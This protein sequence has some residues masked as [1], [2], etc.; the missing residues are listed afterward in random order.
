MAFSE[1]FLEELRARAGLAD[2]ISR[3]VKLARKGR[4]HLGLCPFHKEKTPSFTVNEEKGFYHC[5]GCG[6]HGSVFDFV[7]ET[8]GLTFPEAVEK[9]AGE[10]GLEVPRATPEDR[11]R[12]KQRQTLFDV[13]E[14]A[15]L[16]FERRLRMPEGKKALD[17]L[18]RR[19]LGDDVIKRFRLGF[20][21]D[22]RGVLKTALA[23]DGIPENLMV[24]AGLIIQPED[25][26]AR[27]GP[28]GSGDT[29]GPEART[30]TQKPKRETYDRFRG[31]VMFPITDPRDRVI[32]FGGRVLESPPAGPETDKSAAP[33]YLNSPE[34]ALFQK[35]RV[36]YG[37]KLASGPA[38]KAGIVIVTEGYTD[39]IALHRA[40]FEYAVAPLGTALTETQIG[41]LWRLAP[42]PVLCFDGDKA[43]VRAA[44]RAL[45]RALP[46]LKP[47]H[48]LRFAL[49]P[50]N[51]DPDSLIQREGAAAF[52]RVLGGALSL[53]DMLWRLVSQGVDIST[54]ER[55]AGLEKKAYDAIGPIRDEKV[56]GFYMR[57]FR[58]R[59]FQTFRPK[60]MRLS[61]RF[62]P[63]GMAARAGQGRQAKSN[64]LVSTPL[65]RGAGEEPVHRRIEELLM[66]TL[67]SHPAI[68]VAHH[69]D[70]AGL[71]MATPEM[72]RLCRAIL[73][74]TESDSGLDTGRLKDHLVEK[75]FEALYMRLTESASLKSD[76]FAWPEAALV[77]AEKGWV[78]TLK[79][80]RRI[81]TLQKEYEALE[82]ELS[83]NTTEEC[84]SR[85]MALQEEMQVNSGNE[86]DLEGYGLASE[87]PVT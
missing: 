59:L 15:C 87:R 5:F 30:G 33:K 79:R 63:T 32:A 40:G 50:Q 25:Q 41:L 82:D 64:L 68:L 75:G 14:K 69:E 21:P 1:Q 83:R 36:L 55:C 11:E 24:G 34:T 46:L 35:G 54:P 29:P 18:K 10:A 48:S 44:G 16:F 13:T 77:D 66:L 86:S 26:E 23:K 38:R 56:R 31:R 19:G 58:D 60:K 70:L 8:D 4:E 37:Q 72:D 22:G 27:T 6:A 67:L 71:D 76:W 12:Q 39:V 57:D 47:G 85:L 51:E 49:L 73:E 81:T 53:S 28:G 65:G 78:Q 7:M 80:Y 17:Y 43:G 84:F 45:E 3:R 42:E 2:V 74:A 20:A 61:G 62:G 9:L 52:A